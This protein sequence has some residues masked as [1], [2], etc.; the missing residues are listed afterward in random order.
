MTTGIRIQITLRGTD[1]FA[2]RKTNCVTVYAYD[3]A[4]DSMTK[5][6]TLF[7]HLSTFG[8]TP[9]GLSFKSIEKYILA[10]AKQDECIFLNYSD[11]MP[12]NEV[13]GD[14]VEYTKKII[15]RFRESDIQIVS[16]FIESGNYHPS[17][18]RDTFKSMYGSDA[19]FIDATKMLEVAKSLNKRFLQQKQ[20]A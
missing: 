7:K 13:P 4:K 15:N 1:D 8:M 17:W 16:F 20:T 6:K 9:E 12:T 11:G 10:D 14:P 3:S 18:V 5:I 19:E 2:G